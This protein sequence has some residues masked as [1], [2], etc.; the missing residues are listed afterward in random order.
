MKYII[1]CHC[2]NPACTRDYYAQ[3]E[4]VGSLEGC[5]KRFKQIYDES[6][7]NGYEVTD[8]HDDEIDPGSI[9][10]DVVNG[11]LECIQ[12]NTDAND[13]IRLP[14]ALYGLTRTSR[15]TPFSLLR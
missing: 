9:V 5:A 2:T 10:S 12:V 1:T 13:V 4:Y 6:T 14:W 3:R 11:N 7:E 8:A 15:C